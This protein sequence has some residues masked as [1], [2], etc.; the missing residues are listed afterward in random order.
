MRRN[1]HARGA[2]DALCGSGTIGKAVQKIFA[3]RAMIVVA[4]RKDSND[5]KVDLAD[6][7][8]IEAMYKAVGPVDHVMCAAGS[9]YFGPLTGAPLDKFFAWPKLTG[10][11]SLVLLGLNAVKPGGSFT[12]VTGILSK[13][14]VKLTSAVA[15]VNAGVNAFVKTACLELPNGLRVNAVSPGLLEESKAAYGSFLPGFGGVPS[16]KVALAYVRSALGGLSGHVLEVDDP[17]TAK[18][19]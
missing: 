6:A 15:A 9:C 16:E 17:Y 13:K 2:S 19:V 18:S 11:I 7:K 12:L 8:S 10:Q 4:G 1:P 3:G 14:P 5:V